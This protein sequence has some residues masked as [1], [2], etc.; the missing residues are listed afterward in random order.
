MEGYFGH[1]NGPQIYYWAW[2]ASLL[3][4]RSSS[5]FPSLHLSF[6]ISHFNCLLIR[7]Q[8]TQLF[9]VFFSSNFGVINE[10]S[11]DFIDLATRLLGNESV[12]ALPCHSKISC[13]FF[14]LLLYLCFHLFPLFKNYK[15]FFWSFQWVESI[16]RLIHPICNIGLNH[17][18]IS[19]FLLFVSLLFLFY[20]SFLSNLC[21]HFRKFTCRFVTWINCMSQGFGEQVISPSM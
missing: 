12:L 16:L 20:Y 1:C 8:K 11:E 14:W 19:W 4:K 17:F 5:S 9:M 7:K 3:K 21:F 2:E 10:N 13:L 18:I 15:V 6:P